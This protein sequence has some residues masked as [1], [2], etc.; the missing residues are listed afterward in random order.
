MVSSLFLHHQVIAIIGEFCCRWLISVFDISVAQF[1]E[2]HHGM[3]SFD[4]SMAS[5]LG[6]VINIFQTGYLFN[7]FLSWNLS[8]PIITSFAGL[9]GGRHYF[10]SSCSRGTA[11]LRFFLFQVGRL[12]RLLVPHHRVRLRSPDCSHHHVCNPLFFSSTID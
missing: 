10:V 11:D 8:I 12:H 1:A 3:T 6:S 9:A 5:C 7:K 4:F 2:E